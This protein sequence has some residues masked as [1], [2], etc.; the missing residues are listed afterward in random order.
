[1]TAPVLSFPNFSEE[2]VL[3]TDASNDGIRAVLSQHY[4][5]KEHVIA[6]ASKALTKA[7][8]NYSVT[9]RELLVVI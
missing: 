9:Q 3:G 7:E 6:Y 4:N 2:F 8:R 1:M 5:G